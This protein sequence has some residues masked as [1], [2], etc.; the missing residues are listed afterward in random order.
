[1]PTIFSHAIFAVVAGKAFT[2]KSVSYWFWFLTAVCAIT[3]DADAVGFSFGVRY[4]SLFGHR[5]LTHSIFFSI[6]FGSFIALI[7]H[8]FLLTELTYTKL[9][10]YFSLVTLSHSL[11]DMLT[12]GGLGVVLFAP[13]SNE[14]FFFPWRPIEVSPI[15]LDFFGSRGAEVIASEIIWIWCPAL[16]IFILTTVI[17]QM[18]KKSN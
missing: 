5:G 12:D 13:F 10:I 4:D 18:R 17:R 1:M 2:E 11:L 8:K 6:L 7:V 14:R 9:T 3:P 16:I 15:G